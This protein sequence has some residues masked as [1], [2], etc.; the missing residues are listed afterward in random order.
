MIIGIFGPTASGKTA[1]SIK[2]AEKI[3]GEIVNCDSVAVY[4]YFNIGSAKPT[5]MERQEAKFHLVDFVEPT[6]LYSAGDYEKD[7][8]KTIDQILETGKIPIVSGGSGLYGKVALEGMDNVPET[9]P[10]IREKIGLEIEQDFPGAVQRLLEIDREFALTL[11]LANPRRVSRALE[12]YELTGEKPSTVYQNAKAPKRP[13]WKAYCIDWDRDALIERINLRVDNMVKEGLFEEVEFLM[14]NFPLTCQPF[15]TI[16]YKECVSF[17]K[18]EFTKDETIEKIKIS[19]RQFA[20]RQRT[21]FRK[22]SNVELIT[23]GDL[24]KIIMEIIGD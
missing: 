13:P 10:Q 5:E 20:K 23:L 2:L 12:I 6:T 1:F 15:S 16:G 4:K 21:W 22:Y 3:N 7:A 8:H 24:D 18:G 9:T 17:F 19:T 14:K 11:D